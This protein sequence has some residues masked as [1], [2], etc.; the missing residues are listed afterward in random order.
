MLIVMFPRVENAES[1]A[2]VSVF[3]ARPCSG[4][5]RQGISAYVKA[6]GACVHRGN[7]YA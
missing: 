2:L 6:G 3:N 5:A 1:E 4:S 7:F